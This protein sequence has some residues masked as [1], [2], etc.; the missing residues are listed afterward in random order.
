[1]MPIVR[2]CLSSA[3]CAVGRAR[4]ARHFFFEDC[5]ATSFYRAMLLRRYATIYRYRPRYAPLSAAAMRLCQKDDLLILRSDVFTPA[6]FRR[7]SASSRSGA[8]T[9]PSL[10]S[11]GRDHQKND[12][13]RAYNMFIEA[14]RIP[15][16]I[17]HA[18]SF[19]EYG[20][21]Q[22]SRNFL[23]TRRYVTSYCHAGVRLRLQRAPVTP[24]FP[25]MPPRPCCRRGRACHCQRYVMPAQRL[26]LFVDTPR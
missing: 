4:L 13:Y 3:P 5:A 22:E 24:R 8:S 21:E 6:R 16:D 11:V 14:T 10:I 15:P 23:P 12:A 17:V 26:R 18:R 25:F 19:R 20:G 9:T 7:A 2:H 1:M